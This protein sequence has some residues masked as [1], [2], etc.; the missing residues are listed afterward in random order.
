[1]SDPS[2]YQANSVEPRRGAVCHGADDFRA[3]GAH[4][5]R[6]ERLPLFKIKRSLDD[7]SSRR[8]ATEEDLKP[9]AATFLGCQRQNVNLHRF[10]I[11]WAFAA[12]RPDCRRDQGATL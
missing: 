9:F 8:S 7:G 3:T 10:G 1:M 6:A 4:Q 12:V 11:G 2:G 5:V